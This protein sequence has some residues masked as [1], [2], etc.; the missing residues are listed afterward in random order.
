MLKHQCT[1]GNSNSHP[2]HAGRIQSIW[3][4]LQETGLRGKC[5]VR[6]PR[7]GRVAHTACRNPVWS[8]GPCRQGACE[9]FHDKDWQ[10]GIFR[11]A[12]WK[13]PRAVFL[14]AQG[15]L[16]EGSP[17]PAPWFLC[18]HWSSASP[19]TPALSSPASLYPPAPLLSLCAP[20]SLC[21]PLSCILIT[22][23]S[24]LAQHT[25]AEVPYFPSGHSPGGTILMLFPHQLPE[26]MQATLQQELE[27]L[28]TS[29]VA[30]LSV[31]S[32]LTFLK[33]LP[34]CGKCQV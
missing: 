26:C 3:S 23:C 21:T 27:K 17:C 12:F 24:T 4:R 13:M 1:C 28:E 6:L 25:V 16:K 11:P 31:S 22:R 33:L 34:V 29:P 30:F 32:H 14:K 15:L 9:H 20:L 18:T 5:E 8:V 19:G 2:E 7:V 10:L